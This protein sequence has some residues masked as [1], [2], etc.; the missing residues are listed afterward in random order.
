MLV[1]IWGGECGP[2]LGCILSWSLSAV[3]VAAVILSSETL[4]EMVCL[5]PA[6]DTTLAVLLL[7][8]C[9]ESAA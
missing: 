5:D 2:C 6:A 7:A 4:D 9:N 3:S 1:A 8:K